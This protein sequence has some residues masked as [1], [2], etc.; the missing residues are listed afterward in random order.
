MSNTECL[1]QGLQQGNE[2]SFTT[3]VD[4]YKTY[5]YSVAYNR[6]GNFTDAEEIVQMV[7]VEVFKNIRSLNEPLKLAQWLHGI[8]DRVSLNWL[9]KYRTKTISFKELGN[10]IAEAKSHNP[11]E[12]INGQEE[13]ARGIKKAMGVYNSLE[14]DQRVVL[15]LKYMESLS[16]DEIANRLGI[17][18][19]AVRG[20]LYRAHLCL[21]Q[22][23]D[24]LK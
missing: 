1:V 9:R 2:Q 13:T 10:E 16:Y 20:K 7:F 4:R 18:S 21:K 22:I 23:K 17:T 6:V 24:S 12:I 8:T 11:M 5:V 3:L 19:D 15:N 14:P